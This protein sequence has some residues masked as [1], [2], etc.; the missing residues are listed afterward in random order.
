MFRA[1]ALSF[2][3]LSDPVFLKV[4]A[5]SLGLTA[6]IFVGLGLLLYFAL[7]WLIGW[8]GWGDGG[9]FAAFGAIL[10]TVLGGWL[11]FRA[12]AMAVI[13][14]FTEE[15][16][17]AVE[18]K[19]YPD[20]HARAVRAGAGEQ[21]RVA[22]GSFGRAIGWNLV[23]LPLYLLLFVTGIGTVIAVF[24]VN[25]LLLARDLADLVAMRHVAEAER[26]AWLKR[27]RWRRL[28]LGGVSA[29]LFLL[30]VA[31]LLAP[32]LSAAMAAHMLHR[33]D[34]PHA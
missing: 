1:L 23:A 9:M 31:N 10:L 7:A 21:V 8:A 6:L 27:T 24:A 28:Q 17:E 25:A 16:V 33:G 29:G 4:L 19:H 30:P 26:P 5:K 11:L 22:L 2:G 12:I 20:R 13:G 34:R 15:I 3:Q 14:L 32:I 18:A